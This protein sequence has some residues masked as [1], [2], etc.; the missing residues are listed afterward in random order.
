[1]RRLVVVVSLALLT[2][3]CTPESTSQVLSNSPYALSTSANQVA[4][5]VRVGELTIEVRKADDCAGIADSWLEAWC[6]DLVVY[7]AGVLPTTLQANQRVDQQ[8]LQLM[9][10][11][12]AWSKLHGDDTIC[13]NPLVG[14]LLSFTAAPVPS[15]TPSVSPAQRCRDGL[16]S[17]WSLARTNGET[18]PIVS[19]ASRQEVRV[20]LPGGL[21]LPTPIPN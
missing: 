12:L 4:F 5:T 16:T 1:M 13:E 17:E 9:Y 19:R 3:A 18:F 15:T 8:M 6:R 20:G 2:A 7:R 11:G 10:A 14:R 21:P